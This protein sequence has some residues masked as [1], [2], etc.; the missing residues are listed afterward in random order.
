M[1]SPLSAA[2]PISGVGSPYTMGMRPPPQ[3]GHFVLLFRATYALRSTILLAFSAMI[4][5]RCDTPSVPYYDVIGDIH[6]E[7][8]KLEGLLAQLGYEDVHGAHRHPSRKAIFVGDLIDRGP[9]QVGVLNTVRRMIEAGS[10]EALMGNH[11][12]NA[13]LYATKDPNVAGGY[14]R[15]HVRKNTEQHS[16]FL[17]Q[18]ASTDQAKW[19]EWVEWFKGMPLWKE[20]PGGLR[21]VHACWHNPSITTVENA[22]GAASSNVTEFFREASVRGS[23][24]YE[25]VEILLKG[26]ELDL[27]SYNLPSFLDRSCVARDHARIRWWRPISTTVQELAEIQHDALQDDRTPYPDIST[28]RCREGERSFEYRGPVPVIFGH[29]WRSWPPSSGNDLTPIT[30]C[31]DFSA[32]AGGP[33]V[34]Y[35]WSGEQTLTTSNYDTYPKMS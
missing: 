4:P 26:P 18:V 10:A 16:Q 15:P 8:E 32:G 28:V 5:R 35:R 6:G 27:T 24:V 17:A 25:A 23:P 11:E 30:A 13:I 33:L 7:A 12:F 34:A 21:V 2:L 14:L 20:L 19:V 9:D 1:N 29:Y 22:L 31:V 3:T